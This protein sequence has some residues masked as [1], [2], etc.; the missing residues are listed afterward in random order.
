MDGLDAVPRRKPV[1]IVE[2]RVW[3]DYIWRAYPKSRCYYKR[4]TA[5]GLAKKWGV[6]GIEAR[7]ALYVPAD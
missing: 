1:W 2:Y 7:A 3:V 6:H 4:G 5:E